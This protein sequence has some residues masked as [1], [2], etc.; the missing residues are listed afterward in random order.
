MSKGDLGAEPHRRQPEVPARKAHQHH[1]DRRGGSTTEGNR[2]SD[3][4]WTVIALEGDPVDGQSEFCRTRH[5]THPVLQPG[6]VSA[7]GPPKEGRLLS[8]GVSSDP[9]SGSDG[10]VQMG[11]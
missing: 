5:H 3:S 2:G 8:R 4:A 9:E 10:P 7:H 11:L 1:L 6:D